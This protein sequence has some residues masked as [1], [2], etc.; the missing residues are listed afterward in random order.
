VRRG[1][2]AADTLYDLGRIPGIAAAQNLLEPAE[3][4]A[5]TLGIDD[6]AVLDF[7]FNLEMTFNPGQRIDGNLNFPV[8]CG[9]SCL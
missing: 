6:L 4:S 5:G 8:S 2:H 3:H 1:T 9:S 7:N